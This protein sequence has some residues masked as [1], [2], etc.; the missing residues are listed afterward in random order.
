[1][2]DWLLDFYE[3][4]ETFH[5][6]LVWTLAVAWLILFMMFA[7]PNSKLIK[8]YTNPLVFQP[9][10]TVQTQLTFDWEDLL[11]NLTDRSNQ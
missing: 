3:D 2:K 6:F 11:A 7:I 8:Q 9:E 5:L 10:S 4:V 1:M